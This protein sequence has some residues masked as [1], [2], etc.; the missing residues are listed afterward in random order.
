M[1][2]FCDCVDFGIDGDRDSKRIKLSDEAAN[3]AQA[4]ND[5]R[6]NT[7]EDLNA[8]IVYICTVI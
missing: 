5:D 7:A 1:M 4:S 6:V 8:S 2:M 3:A